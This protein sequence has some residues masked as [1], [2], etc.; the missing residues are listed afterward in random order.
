M[1][2]TINTLW[3]P[4]YG[5]L[6][7][8]IAL[9][10]PEW[11]DLQ[12]LE[13]F[14]RLSMRGVIW[15]VE[16]VN[17]GGIAMT[18]NGGSTARATSNAPVEATDTWR[19]MVGR[20]EVGFDELNA[21]NDSA[22]TSAQTEKQLKYQAAD[23]LR[24]FRRAV[25]VGFYGFPDAILFTTVASGHSN[26]NG[27]TL[28]LHVGNLYGISGLNPTRFRDYL[29]AGKDRVAVI[30]N[31]YTT[32]TIFASGD[33]TAISESGATLDITSA[34]SSAGVTGGMAIVLYNQVLQDGVTDLNHGING[35]SHLTRAAVVH[36]IAESDQPDW[37]PGYR[38]LAY[39]AA[40]S[41]TSLYK[42]FE[43]I[44]M[45][46]DH[47]PTWVNT[48]TG[49]IAAAGGAQLDQRRYGADEDTMR[50]GFKNLNVMGVTA[51]AR[52]YVPTGH[53]FIGS[54]GALRKMS[55]DE[56]VKDV[57]AGGG[58]RNGFKEYGNQLGFY[59]D[60]IMRAQLTVVSRLGLGLAAGVTEA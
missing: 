28:R 7:R 35:L 33:L 11:K 29:T 30:A 57:L 16:L 20:F 58:D 24:S 34:V 19:H 12:K 48:T 56:D 1:L 44:E 55:P 3:Q 46:S 13:N 49:V 59:K 26:P 15:P 43:E 32:P 41:G 21:E 60:Q 17:G 10:T 4:I 37:V 38:N 6:V 23:K 52:P 27:S 14:T 5:K 47:A 25:A 2:T 9:L 50:L 51:S 18:S 40:L 39:G 53:A 45:R 22:F 36:N 54:N 42:I 8:A 31:P